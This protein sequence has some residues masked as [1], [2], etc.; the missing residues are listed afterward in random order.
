MPLELLITLSALPVVVGGALA[1]CLAGIRAGDQPGDATLGTVAHRGS[2]TVR[3]V[4]HNPG[5]VPVLVGLSVRRGSL[6]VRLAGGLRVYS[7]HRTSR[8]RLRPGRQAIVGVVDAGERASWTVPVPDVTWPTLE[9]VAVVGQANRLRVIER[10]IDR[11]GRG[12]LEPTTLGLRAAH[13]QGKATSA[14][15]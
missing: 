10:R 13:L 1:A 15:C 9:L 11:T 7:P 12:G 14:G 5:R 8:G 6:P 3:A 2:S 4:I